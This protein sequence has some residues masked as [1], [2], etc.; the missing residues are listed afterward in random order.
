[1]RKRGGLQRVAAALGA[2]LL[3]RDPLYFV[4]DDAVQRVVGLGVVDAVKKSR[5]IVIAHES[6]PTTAMVVDAL[7]GVATNQRPH[8]VSGKKLM[9]KTHVY[10]ADFV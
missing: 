10:F 4:V 5:D 6:L 2:K 1:M 3:A 7:P 9:R 8:S